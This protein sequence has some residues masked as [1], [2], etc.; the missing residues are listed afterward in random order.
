RNHMRSTRYAALAGVAIAAVAL[1]GCAGPT[2][3]GDSITLT[4]WH[5]TQDPDAV[6]ATYEAYEQETGNRIELVPI[7]A[8]GFEEATLTKW[9]TGERPDVLEFHGMSSYIAM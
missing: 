2:G 4:V 7:S 9:A 1:A 6:L 8:D 5:N 3:D